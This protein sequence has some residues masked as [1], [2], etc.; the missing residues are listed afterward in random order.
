MATTIIAIATAIHNAMPADE[1]VIGAFFGFI[2]VVV[3]IDCIS[4]IR[5]LKKVKV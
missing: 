2:A 1:Y 4:S 5:T 3:I